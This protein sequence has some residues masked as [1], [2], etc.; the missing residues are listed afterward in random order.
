MFLLISISQSG[1]NTYIFGCIKAQASYITSFHNDSK[2]F[3]EHVVLTRLTRNTEGF[4]FLK[5]IEHRRW[6]SDKSK[7]GHSADCSLDFATLQ[8]DNCVN[9]KGKNTTERVGSME[10][11]PCYCG[12]LDHMPAHKWWAFVM[13]LKGPTAATFSETAEQTWEANAI[14][15]S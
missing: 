11:R 3:K 8:Q 10:G 9:S 4:K 12:G 6:V 14:N 15:S 2:V 1:A 13:R 7:H 5:K